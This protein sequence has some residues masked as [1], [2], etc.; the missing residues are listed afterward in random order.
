MRD[1][2]K[3]EGPI[4]LEDV[5]ALDNQPASEPAPAHDAGERITISGVTAEELAASIRACDG[6]TV[7]MT[8]PERAMIGRVAK[9]ERLPVP[10]AIEAGASPASCPAWAA[11]TFHPKASVTPRPRA[12]RRRN[13]K[14]VIPHYVFDLDERQAFRP[15]GYPW[16]CVGTLVATS[17]GKTVGRGSGF[18]VGPRTVLTAGHVL[19]WGLPQPGMIFTA[20]AYRAASLGT[21]PANGTLATGYDTKGNATAWDFA[22]VRLDRP[23]GNALGWFGFR[24]YQSAWE[25]RPDFT[26]VGYPAQVLWGNV[27]I[28]LGGVPTR[29]LGIS[30]EDDDADGDALELEHYG[31]LSVGNSGGPLFGWWGSPPLPFAIGVN[32]GGEAVDYGV[33]KDHNNLTAGG[34]AMLE[35]VRW[36]NQ[37]WP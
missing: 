19:P 20:G 36:A 24:T 30:I 16:H 15:E 32:V 3:D 22:V 4:C 21:R 28:D 18:L 9:L 12:L 31:D 2:K 37:T 5:L 26:A 33:T 23:I 35:L 6:G 29:Q 8:L 11:K 27:W 13:G 34:K 7:E 14:R 10:K 1:E 17:G 25:D